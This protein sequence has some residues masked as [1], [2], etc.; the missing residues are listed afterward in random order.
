VADQHKVMQDVSPDR[1]YQAITNSSEFYP[2][3]ISR[4]VFRPMKTRRESRSRRQHLDT[5]PGHVLAGHV[6]TGR[7]ETAYR[8]N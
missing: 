3:T 1:V 8:A 7:P 4:T 6:V 5:N 2:D